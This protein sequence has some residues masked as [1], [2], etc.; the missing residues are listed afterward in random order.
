MV[1]LPTERKPAWYATRYDAEAQ[2]TR[3][4]S[5]GTDDFEQAKQKLLERY[6]EQHRPQNATAET[7]ALAD[8]LLDYY[9]NHGSQ[10]RSAGSVKTSCAIGSNSSA[11]RAS[12]RRPDRRSLK[13]LSPI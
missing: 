2:R 10:A 13:A 3:R 6:L 1:A 12:P 8:V 11:R 7:V 4:V 5:L 9:K